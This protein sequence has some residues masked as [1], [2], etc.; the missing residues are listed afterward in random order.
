MVQGRQEEH[1][2]MIH[3]NQTYGGQNLNITGKTGIAGK[4][5]PTQAHGIMW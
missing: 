1:I 2:E 3:D 4:E 5:L